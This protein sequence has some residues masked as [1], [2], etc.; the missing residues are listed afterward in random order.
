MPSV[1]TEA[2]KVQESL[3]AKRPRSPVKADAYVSSGLGLL[4]LAMS[5]RVHGGVAKG[6]YVYLV[7]DS[8]SAKT[9][10][11][12]SVLAEA[13]LN[14]NFDD[15][16]LVYDQA[17]PNAAMMDIPFYFGKA[18]EKRIR[19]PH[20]TWEDRQ[21]SETLRE[22]YTTAKRAI[23]KG[24][25]IYGID[26]LD[27]LMDEQE[28]AET[29]KKEKLAQSGEKVKGSFFTG[30]ARTNSRNIKRLTS[31]LK[32]NG[33]ILL[34]ISQTRDKLGTFFPQKTHS[35][36]HALRFHAQVEVW[37]SVVG[38]IRKDIRNKDRVIG[39]YIQFRV[40]KNRL[41]GW[42]GGTVKVRFYRT[43]G[44]DEVGSLTD[45]LIEEGHWP[46]RKGIITADEF[47]YEGPQEK[48]IRQ[49]DENSQVGDLQI[50]VQKVWREIDDACT[51]KRRRR[52]E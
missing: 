32:A 23:V 25:T 22:F 18:L 26:D 5:G 17:D 47:N 30:P 48:L 1:K 38:T 42:K 28:E 21:N 37:S 33:S 11:V 29:E 13:S 51:V 8:M 45:Y 10:V 19:P 34:A 3:A 6:T 39:S 31:R 12:L 52:Y 44:F 20:G 35:G 15:Y 50:L 14:K 9:W 49:I 46:K 36:G 40:E 4:N 41:T 7:G 27:S 2:V 16:E 24:P 43:L